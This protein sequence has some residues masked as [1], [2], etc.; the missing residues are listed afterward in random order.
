MD[1]G[2]VNRLSNLNAHN[3]NLLAT[4]IAMLVVEIKHTSNRVQFTSYYVVSDFKIQR[5]G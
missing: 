1:I 2:K 3:P 5:T 4:A